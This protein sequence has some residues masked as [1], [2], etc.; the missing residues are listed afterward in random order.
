MFGGSEEQNGFPS[1][2]FTR[3]KATYELVLKLP[4]HS[5]CL[6]TRLMHAVWWLRE[7]SHLGATTPRENAV[8]V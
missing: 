8:D 7:I 6:L 5:N 4:I 3:R 1:I 2:P